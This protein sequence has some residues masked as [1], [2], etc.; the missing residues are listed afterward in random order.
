M[1]ESN[2]DVDH[3]K[4][5]K[6]CDSILMNAPHAVGY[7]GVS[8]GQAA[9]LALAYQDTEATLHTLCRIIKIDVQV[10]RLLSDGPPALTNAESDYGQDIVA[11]R[12]IPKCLIPK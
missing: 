1:T 4:A 11:P 5:R 8:P 10:A 9:N 2:Q 3:E 12:L 6:T 7:L